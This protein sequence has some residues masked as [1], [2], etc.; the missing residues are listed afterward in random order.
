MKKY[1]RE[2]FDA[3]TRD[4]DGY[5]RVPS[6]NWSKVHFNG[7]EKLIFG[8]RNKFGDWNK[9]G[10]GNKFGSL[11]TF[12]RWNTFGDDNKFSNLNK[13]GSFNK[14]GG[15][16]KFGA[17]NTFDNWNTFR[18]CNAFGIRNEFGDDN[19]FG[20]ENTFGV[21][22]TF[23]RWNTFGDECSMED[24]SVRNTTMFFV[25]NIGSENRTAY[26][27][28]NMKTGEI[29][30]R[31]GCWFST[32]EEFVQRVKDVHAGTQHEVDYLAFAEFAKVRFARYQ[33]KEDSP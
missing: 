21:R 8:D 33:R 26:A 16:N 11:N 22:N 6:G 12:G 5:I 15:L 29:F 2:D 23:G 32:I 10:N 30:I 13:F 18:D 27:F 7:E 31:A 24:G 14:F 17:G 20:D 19:K 4:A 28:C 3:L 25:S 9:F 1:T